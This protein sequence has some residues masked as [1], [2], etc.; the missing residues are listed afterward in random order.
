MNAIIIK[1]V[2]VLQSIK[3]LL[4]NETKGFLLGKVL[5]NC[6]TPKN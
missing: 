3:K 6:G 5:P 1:I 4:D 2:G